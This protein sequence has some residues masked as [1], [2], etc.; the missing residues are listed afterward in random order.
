MLNISTNGFF[1]LPK[2]ADIGR[3]RIERNMVSLLCKTTTTIIIMVV[4]TS[5]TIVV[6]AAAVVV[7]YK[8]KLILDFI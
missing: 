6:G 8:W 7:V 5:T 1:F 4:W 3:R 2:S